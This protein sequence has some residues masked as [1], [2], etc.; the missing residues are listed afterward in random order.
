MEFLDIFLLGVGIITFI[1]AAKRLD[2]VSAAESF[3]SSFEAVEAEG[4]REESVSFSIRRD[5]L[6]LS[7]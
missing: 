2:I 6:F 1:I 4:I 7:P 5:P 3:K